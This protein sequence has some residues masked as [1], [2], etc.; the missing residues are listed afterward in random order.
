MNFTIKERVFAYDSSPKDLSAGDKFSMKHL[1]SNVYI[2][3]A[4]VPVQT[5]SPY[6]DSQVKPF[7]DELVLTLGNHTLD[8]LVCANLFTGEIFILNSDEENEMVHIYD[9]KD[10]ELV[11]YQ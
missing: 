11:V 2:V 1:G 9:N 8:I 7:K 10:L 4:D 3:L 6:K 5:F